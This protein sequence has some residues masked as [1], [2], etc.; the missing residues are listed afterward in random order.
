MFPSTEVSLS[1]AEKNIR[2]IT[3]LMP[4]LLFGFTGG[5][6]LWE[7]KK[8]FFIWVKNKRDSNGNLVSIWCC[9]ADKLN[10]QAVSLA[11]HAVN[12]FALGVKINCE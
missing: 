7:P 9:D 1:D 5:S 8:Q 11:W 10:K 4:Q 12:A 6:E 2:K 3:S